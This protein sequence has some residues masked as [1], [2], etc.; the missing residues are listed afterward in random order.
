MEARLAELSEL[1]QATRERCRRL[2]QERG[3]TSEREV[4]EKVPEDQGQP[5]LAPGDMS[6]MQAM[7]FSRVSQ[8]IERRRRSG[9]DQDKEVESVAFDM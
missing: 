7:R 9:T 2:E 6:S 8:G 5:S 4:E 1:V 3:E